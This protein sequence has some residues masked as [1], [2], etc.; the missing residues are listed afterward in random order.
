MESGGIAPNILNDGTKCR[1]PASFTPPLLCFGE[2]NPT[3]HWTQAGLDAVEIR[4][5]SVPAEINPHSSVIQPALIY[6]HFLHLIIRTKFCQ[7][8]GLIY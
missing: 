6:A 3:V 8:F 5:T 1:C 2:R 7:Q 4:I